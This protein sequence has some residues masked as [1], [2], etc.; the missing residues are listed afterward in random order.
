MIVHGY[1]VETTDDIVYIPYNIC[2]LYTEIEAD[3]SKVISKTDIPIAVAGLAIQDL[4]TAIL[5]EVVRHRV[6]YITIKDK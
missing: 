4:T 5:C 2:E 6:N 3:A 1:A